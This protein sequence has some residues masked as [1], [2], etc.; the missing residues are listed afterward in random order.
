MQLW[1]KWTENKGFHYMSGD[2]LPRS[3]ITTLLL[4]AWRVREDV[5]LQTQGC[6]T[7]N[8]LSSI[9]LRQALCLWRLFQP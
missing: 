8:S 6:L 4:F 9:P 1:G 2:S 3:F 7:Q 5:H